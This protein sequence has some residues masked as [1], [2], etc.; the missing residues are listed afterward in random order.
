MYIFYTTSFLFNFKNN[1]NPYYFNYNYGT[2]YIQFINI[3]TKLTFSYKI[4][5]IFHLIMI[6]FH[7]FAYKVNVKNQKIF[8]LLMEFLLKIINID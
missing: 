5:L 1:F 4:I 2:L 3:Y 8:H 6:K 7:Y